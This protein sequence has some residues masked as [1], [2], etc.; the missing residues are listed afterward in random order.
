M[1]AYDDVFRLIA[2]LAGGTFGYLLFLLA[3][4]AR[5]ERRA[6]LEGTT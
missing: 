2:V 5:R 4:R 6:R 1:L 3:R